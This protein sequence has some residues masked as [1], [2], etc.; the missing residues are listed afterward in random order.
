[1]NLN[2]FGF[3]IQ[4]KILYFLCCIPSIFG[5]KEIAT[6]TFYVRIKPVSGINS[7]Q[8]AHRIAK[9]TGFSNLG[10]V[11]IFTRKDNPGKEMDIVFGDFYKFLIMGTNYP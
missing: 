11:S 8:L 3:F 6:N 4:L 10:P 7:G 2:L 9:R 5:S 1:M